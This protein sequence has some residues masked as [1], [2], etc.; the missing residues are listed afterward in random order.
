MA[1]EA[2]W[3]SPA[4]GPVSHNKQGSPHVAPRVLLWV[5]A[6]PALP[7]PWGHLH[8]GLSGRRSLDVETGAA[9]WR[10]AFG[11]GG[12]HYELSPGVGVAFP[13]RFHL[14]RTNH[15]ALLPAVREEEVESPGNDGS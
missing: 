1:E 5:R 12:N 14:C 15:I 10:A 8:A 3:E 7:G 13:T 6:E 4:A 2:I 11:G 9:C